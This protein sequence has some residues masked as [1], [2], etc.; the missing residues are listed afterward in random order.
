MVKKDNCGDKSCDH[1]RDS[2][3]KELVST[4][5]VNK[6]ATSRVPQYFACLAPFCGCKKYIPPED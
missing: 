4:G 1:V 3:H 6:V 2:H 5:D